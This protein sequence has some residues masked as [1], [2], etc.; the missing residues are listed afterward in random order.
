MYKLIPGDLRAFSELHDTLQDLLDP[1]LPT[2]VIVECVFI[3]L[4]PTHSDS[5]LTWF[6]ERYRKAGLACLLYDPVGLEDS[7]GK[8]MINNLL[9]SHVNRLQRLRAILIS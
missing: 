4:D 6:V 8:V 1:S 5:I 3:Y 7:F 2:L 9:V